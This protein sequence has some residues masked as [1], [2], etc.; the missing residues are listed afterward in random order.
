MAAPAVNVP[1]PA[2]VVVSS[3]RYL[4]YEALN[5]GNWINWKRRTT[6]ALKTLHAW[7]HVESDLSAVR[8]DPAVDPLITAA[9]LAAWDDVEIMAVTQIELNMENRYMIITRGCA[10]ARDAWKQ[11]HDVFVNANLT[12]HMALEAELTNYTHKQGTSVEDHIK[13]MQE[14]ADR[15]A[16]SGEPWAEPRVVAV[17][18][19]SMPEEYKSVVKILQHCSNPADRTLVRV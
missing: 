8:P 19:R 6:N 4:K 7:A 11:L 16:I 9:L 17:V 10:T 3:P 12:S 2:V 1:P 5:A 15:I 14:I 13:A 18:L